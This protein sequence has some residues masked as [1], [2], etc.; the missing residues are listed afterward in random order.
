MPDAD[1]GYKASTPVQTPGKGRGWTWLVSYVKRKF[2]ERSAKKQEESTADRSARLTANAT[3][4]LAVFTVI[5][6]ATSV[7][8]V[9][10]LRNQLREMHSGGADTK[11]LAEAA[12][13]QAEEAKE[14]VGKMAE[15]LT[16][17]D[18]LIIQATA[19]AA[20]TNRLA[21]Q[22]QRSA[23][24]ARD[25]IKTSVEAD[26]P[27]IV[28]DFPPHNKH[29]IQ[30]ANLEWHNGGNVPAVAVFSATEY[31]VPVFPHQLHT[32]TEMEIE[33]KKK[34]ISTWQ[35]K[36]FVAQDERYEIALDNTPP[37]SGQAPIDI[38]GC[39]W[40]TDILSNTE[41]TTEFF[42][43]AIQN[44]FMFPESDGVSLFYLADRPF[45]YK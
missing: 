9:W 25:A 10:I 40:Y 26:R 27:W 41:R 12:K 8:T 16:K 38:H 2:H 34:P 28:P 29:T 21:L 11:A 45:V 33:L 43:T 4:V 35:Y 7:G 22:A 23:D 44:K 14:Q 20:A 18:N 32:C 42:Y 31:F 19:E 3:V 36:G 5:L 39:V 15:S 30:E 17:T 6:A 1:H 13:A 24:Y 37:W